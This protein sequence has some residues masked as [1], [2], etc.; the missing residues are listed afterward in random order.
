MFEFGW[1]FVIVDLNWKFSCMI[2]SKIIFW[3][4]NFRYFFDVIYR[5]IIFYI[6]LSSWVFVLCCL[7]GFKC[8]EFRVGCGDVEIFKVIFIV[9]C[10]FGYGLYYFIVKKFGWKFVKLNL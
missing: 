5:R 1:F 8:E 4:G 9:V 2:R 6:V 10:E 3:N 7:C